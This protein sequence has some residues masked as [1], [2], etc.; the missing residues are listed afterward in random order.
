[1]PR[2]RKKPSSPRAGSSLYASAGIGDSLEGSDH[3]GASASSSTGAADG[4][5]SLSR[6]D[7]RAFSR[8]VNTSLEHSLED[9]EIALQAATGVADVDDDEWQLQSVQEIVADAR[10]RVQAQKP[11]RAE[12]DDKILE[13]RP[14]GERSGKDRGYHIILPD[15]RVRSLDDSFSRHVRAQLLGVKEEKLPDYGYNAAQQPLSARRR[16]EARP[17]PRPKIQ[18]PWYLPVKTWYTKKPEEKDKDGPRFTRSY[19]AQLQELEARLM[20]G[21]DSGGNGR[22]GASSVASG[23]E[24]LPTRKERK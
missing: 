14:H 6:E 20:N 17:K 21:G 19:V 15:N 13:T 18:N 4:L 23:A 5:A 3:L 9:P 12:M 11:W 7:A 22:G 24:D 10:R 2:P 8:F 16:D 1:M